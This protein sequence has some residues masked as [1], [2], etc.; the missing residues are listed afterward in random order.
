[1]IT[2]NCERA[3]M[4]S[5]YFSYNNCSYTIKA[6]ALRVKKKN[7]GK[8]NEARITAHTMRMSV[9]VADYRFII[10]EVNL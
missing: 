1:M 7:K 4:R 5:P 2:R 9:E 10:Q 6:A 3:I 8:I